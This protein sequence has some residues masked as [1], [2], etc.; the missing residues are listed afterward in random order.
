[1]PPGLTVAYLPQAARLR[2]ERIESLWGRQEQFVTTQITVTDP[3][4]GKNRGSHGDSPDRR[5]A[6]M[7]LMSANRDRLARVSSLRQAIHLESWLDIGSYV[8]HA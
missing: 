1:M 8:K 3:L 4:D 2:R 5:V 7:V 6:A